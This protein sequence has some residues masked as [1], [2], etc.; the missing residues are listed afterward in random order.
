ML[1]DNPTIRTAATFLSG[2]E[3]IGSSES[4]NVLNSD[5]G[6]INLGAD[7]TN[8][9]AAV[10]IGASTSITTVNDN[11]IVLGDFTVQG[12]VTTINTTNL[13]VEDRYILLN[14]GSVGG[15]SKGGLVVDSGNGAG[16][17][18]ILGEASGRW[19]FTGSLAQDAATA[20][21]DAFVAAV[22]TS[23]IAEYEKVGNIRIDTVTGDIYIYA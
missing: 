10:N 18:F 21:P 6:I 19:G 5:V 16:K 11:L 15:V 3:I 8:G 23:E 7:P 2:S 4:F 12:D 17:A 20:T 14:S 13:L 1:I 22:V 9:A